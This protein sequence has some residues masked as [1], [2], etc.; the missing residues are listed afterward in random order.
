MEYRIKQSKLFEKKVTDLLAYLE[1]SWNKKVAQDFKQILDRKMLQLIKEPDSGRNS[2]KIAG[3]QWI[4]I[5][6]HNKLFYRIKGDII[7]MI[8]LFDTRQD[9]KKNKYE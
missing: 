6:K 1:Q 8:T 2:Q 5:T 9:P 3:V 7:Y 4:L